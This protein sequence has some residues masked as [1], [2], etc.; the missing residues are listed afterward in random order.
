MISQSVMKMKYKKEC[1]AQRSENLIYLRE[2]IAKMNLTDFSKEIGIVKTNL[3]DIEKGNR[4]LSISNLHS[5][6]TYFR[7]KHNLTISA[8]YLLGY[9]D[10]IENKSMNMAQD[11]ALSRNAIDSI[12]GMSEAERDVFN[13]LASDSDIFYLLLGQLWLYANNSTFIDIHIHDHIADST[14]KIT[15]KDE[16]DVIMRFRAI[17]S[18]NLILQR[19]KNTYRD[20][21]NNRADDL[22]KKLESKLNLSKGE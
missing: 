9:T 16:V 6:K 8:D 2:Q 17:D 15:D 21:V 3:S 5:Y 4:D 10:M 19:I 20:E 13:R 1:H 11:L 22:V 7:E 14:E 18:F 12:I